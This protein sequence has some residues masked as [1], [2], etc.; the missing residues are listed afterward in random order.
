MAWPME[1][2]G[3]HPWY[4]MP[5]HHH[6]HHAPPDMILVISAVLG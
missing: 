4:H 3:F 6:H 2:L 1:G 5:P